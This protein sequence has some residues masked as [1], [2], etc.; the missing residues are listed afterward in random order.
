MRKKMKKNLL[1]LM[2]VVTFLCFGATFAS[3][4]TSSPTKNS[5]NVSKK[6]SAAK[7]ISNKIEALK[8]KCK[9]NVPCQSQLQDLLEANFFYGIACAD[10]GYQVGCS[11]IDE[12]YLIQTASI[13]ELCLAWNGY[14]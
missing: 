12:A 3:A 2:F 14:L 4:K 5:A 10:G 7:A 11:P 13:Y 1:T 6:T 9:A 8:A